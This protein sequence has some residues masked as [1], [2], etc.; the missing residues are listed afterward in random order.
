MGVV[1]AALLQLIGVV[2]K[3]AAPWQDVVAYVWGALQ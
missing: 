1:L 3:L 2:V